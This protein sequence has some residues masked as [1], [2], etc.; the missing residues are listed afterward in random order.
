MLALYHEVLFRPIYNFTIALYDVLWHD[1]GLA[2]LALTVL[3]R[4][5]LWPLTQKSLASQK[6]MQ[7]IQPKIKAVQ[8]QYKDDKERQAKEM[9][10]L[11]KAEKVSPFSSCLPLLIQLPLFIALYQALTAGLHSENLSLLYSFV[12]NPGS[13]STTT[14]GFLDLSARSIPL[15][16]LA[17]AVQY[18]QAK[19]MSTQR[20]AV[21][22]EGSKD[23]DAMAMM[24]KQMLY[25]MP[26]LTLFIGV[27]LPAGLTLY[28]LATN[29]MMVVQQ[30]FFFK[31]KPVEVL[32]AR[33]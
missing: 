26:A 2:I 23:E 31:K 6:A 3:V 27:S 15:A 24:N 4:F 10:A 20:P 17:A 1:L 32:P 29:V 13:V 28:W 33:P 25:F 18:V 8:A 19:M 9:M 21:K 12:G 5:A 7:D 22:G 30:Y 11:Y 16:V 14:L